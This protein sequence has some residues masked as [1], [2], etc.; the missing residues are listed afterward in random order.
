M[1]SIRNLSWLADAERD[2]HRRHQPDG[3]RDRR[4]SRGMTEAGKPLALG[5]VYRPD[6]T[7]AADRLWARSLVVRHAQRE[8]CALLDIFEL[9]DNLVRNAAVLD[10][11]AALADSG[12]VVVLVTHGLEPDLASRLANEFGLRHEPVQGMSGR[13]PIDI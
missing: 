6:G 7:A 11:L 2:Q 1:N 12:D 4:R 10:R 5:L 13:S 3:I 9:D 8:G